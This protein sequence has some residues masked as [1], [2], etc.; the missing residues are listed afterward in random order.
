[1]EG[2]EGGEAW[3]YLGGGGGGEVSGDDVYSE[4]GMSFVGRMVD[5]IVDK[6]LHVT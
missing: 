5:T 4:R 3:L 1:M 6:K 2:A